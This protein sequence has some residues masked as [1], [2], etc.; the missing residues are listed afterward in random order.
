MRPAGRI[1]EWPRNVW[2]A[3]GAGG[4]LSAP[5][6]PVMPADSVAAF[7]RPGGALP[8]PVD[9]RRPPG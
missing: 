6:V 3:A 8:L 7:R 1:V 2:S 4:R 9:P 5:A